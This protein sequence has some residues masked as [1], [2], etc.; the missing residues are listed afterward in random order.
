M[1]DFANYLSYNEKWLA[2]L[3][4]DFGITIITNKSRSIAR[5]RIIARILHNLF[6]NLKVNV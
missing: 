3:K 6:T 1:T 2:Y 5:S 4:C